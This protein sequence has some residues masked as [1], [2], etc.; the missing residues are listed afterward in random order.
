MLISTHMLSVYVCTFVASHAYPGIV[1][2]CGAATF[3]LGS[4]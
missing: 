2:R 4:S 1:Y 3:G